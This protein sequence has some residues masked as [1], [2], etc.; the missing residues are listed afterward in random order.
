MKT[1]L[2]A[3]ALAGTLLSL[4]SAQG[5]VQRVTVALYEMG[6]KPGQLQLKAGVPAEIT[7]RNAG[8]AAH[9][10]QAYLNPKTAPKGESSWDAYLE[11]NT[12]WLG[13]KAQLEIG[14]RTMDASKW[15]EVMLKPGEQAVLRF[16]P[17]KKGN[18]E[19]GCHL[20]GHYE[21]GM[22]GSVVVR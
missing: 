13:G 21:A 9:E 11:Q 18:Y 22:R 20:P 12:L 19:L 3:L 4:A 14:G 1:Y 17:V 16:T 2:K 8:K 5:Q 10:F 7:L 15:I 6:F